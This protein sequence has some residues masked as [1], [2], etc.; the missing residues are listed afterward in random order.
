MKA[1]VF[2]LIA[3]S[4][5]GL[6]RHRELEALRA[7]SEHVSESNPADSSSHALPRASRDASS[8]LLSE[9]PAG[10]DS[11]VWR[12]FG[13]ML[14]S[15]DKAMLDP[16]LREIDATLAQ[17]DHL[18]VMALLKKLLTDHRMDEEQ[19]NGLQ[20]FIVMRRFAIV[21]PQEA[22]RL[23]A[24]LPDSSFPIEHAT[25]VF[26]LWTIKRPAEAIHWFD[27][28]EGKDRERFATHELA[29]AVMTSQA[30][31][32]PAGAFNRILNLEA[33]GRGEL[34]G[35][36]GIYAQFAMRG[37]EHLDF[38]TALTA[39]ESRAPHSSVLATIRKEYVDEL[40]NRLGELP[41]DQAAEILDHGFNAEDRLKIATK[42]A[43]FKNLTEP[44]RWGKWLAAQ[45]VQAKSVN[46]LVRFS[47]EWSMG[48]IL[49]D[50]HSK[51][52]DPA[53]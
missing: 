49:G 29:F 5:I 33:A 23:L 17:M 43:S 20:Y 1:P 19:R 8:S 4:I 11:K 34:A 35:S 14:R 45:G 42:L 44:E 48:D 13:P 47:Q 39:A 51:D 6:I 36:F 27:S 30:R 37:S 12:C 40:P 9:P 15:E 52:P 53:Q 26:R 28:L 3:A 18:A 7:Q 21:N 38:L 16:A 31:F 25:S 24:A 46:P 22:M 2:I 50:S 32:D 41:F 10:L